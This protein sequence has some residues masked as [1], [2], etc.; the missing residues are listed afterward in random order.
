MIGFDKPTLFE[1][2]AALGHLGPHWSCAR[3]AAAATLFDRPLAGV[4]L[5]AVLPPRSTGRGGTRLL[6]RFAPGGFPGRSGSLCT[7]TQRPS[8]LWRRSGPTWCQ[9]GGSVCGAPPAPNGT[10]CAFGGTGRTT[11]APLI[12]AHPLDDRDARTGP[13]TVRPVAERLSSSRR[14]PRRPPRDSA[15]GQRAATPAGQS[16]ETRRGR[17]L[18]RR[19]PPLL[20]YLSV[21][22][23]PP[24]PPPQA[25]RPSSSGAIS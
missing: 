24:P 19:R 6:A 18:S 8:P 10:S 20:C 3:A 1:R 4:R 7:R 23:T 15:A 14:L 25:C 22:R 17:A 2:S 13:R 21:G 9:R 11:P 5:S 16:S 12:P